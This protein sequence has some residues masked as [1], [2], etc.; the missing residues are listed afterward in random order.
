[1]GAGGK[2]VPALKE[3][4]PAPFRCSPQGTEHMAPTTANLPSFI[5]KLEPL[6]WTSQPSY[7]SF[8][9]ISVVN[10]KIVSWS[11]ALRQGAPLTYSECAANPDWKSAFTNFFGTIAFFTAILNPITGG[12]LFKYVL[13]A[14]GQGPSME[15]M[16][17]ESFASIYAQGTGT[18]GSK[19]EALIY[20]QG[21]VGYLETARMLS[22]SG[23]ALAL[24]PRDQLPSTDKG[25]FFSPSY[26]LGNALLE[27][28]VQ[29][30]TQFTVRSLGEGKH[31]T[32]KQD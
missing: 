22:E 32:S 21:C 5:S 1:M 14:P 3:G 18:K 30:G 25:G 11:Q 24:A 2:D 29:T 15:T 9:V 26:G 13:P 7:G 31:Q 16:T 6:P 10:S 12:L 17:K 4:A 23:I 19:V 28:L 8:F 27:R 20:F